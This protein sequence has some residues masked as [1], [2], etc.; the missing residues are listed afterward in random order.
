MKRITVFLIA[1]LLVGSI[2]YS[3]KAI[4]T[5]A[6]GGTGTHLAHK[7]LFHNNATFLLGNFGTTYTKYVNFTIDGHTFEQCPNVNW[8]N[9]M[10]KLNDDNSLAWFKH[11]TYAENED[12]R[13]DIYNA[14]LDS[15][16]NLFVLFRIEKGGKVVFGGDEFESN[17]YPFIVAKYS[18]NGT[19]IWHRKLNSSPE[20]TVSSSGNLVLVIAINRW[21]DFRFSHWDEDYF[22]NGAND[23]YGKTFRMIVL[24]GA[25]G[26]MVTNKVLTSDLYHS[27]NQDEIDLIE[28][29]S[30]DLSYVTLTK[31]GEH[32]VLTLSVDYIGE[33]NLFYSE[34]QLEKRFVTYGP[35]TSGLVKS[36]FDNT[37][38]R[39]TNFNEDDTKSHITKYNSSLTEVI[40]QGEI[41]QPAFFGRSIVDNDGNIIIMSSQFNSNTQYNGISLYMDDSPN[42]SARFT[43]LNSNLE[44]LGQK[45]LYYPWYSNSAFNHFG[46]NSEKNSIKTI[47]NES[48]AINIDTVLFYP[49]DYNSD[50]VIFDFENTGILPK[51]LTLRNHTTFTLNVGESKELAV[52]FFNPQQLNVEWVLNGNTVSSEPNYT[53]NATS[54]GEF[55]LSLKAYDPNYPSKVFTKHWQVNV[56][57]AE[58]QLLFPQGHPLYNNDIARFT[59]DSIG[60][61][62]WGIDKYKK[63]VY[64]VN[65]DNVADYTEWINPAETDLNNENPMEVRLDA[66]RNP[67]FLMSSGLVL[68]KS[69]GQWAK[70]SLTDMGITASPTQLC[71]IDGVM[72][73]STENGVVKTGEVWEDVPNVEVYTTYLPTYSNP[74][75]PNTTPTRKVFAMHQTTDGNFWIGSEYGLKNLTTG[76]TLYPQNHGMPFN[77]TL[78]IASSGN[79]LYFGDAQ[80][81]LVE[82]NVE[83]NKFRLFIL[84]DVSKE[85]Y[86]DMGIRSMSTDANGNVWFVNDAGGYGYGQG[87]FCLNPL[88]KRIT[89]YNP[90]VSVVKTIT[91]GQ[92]NTVYARIDGRIRVLNKEYVETQGVITFSVTNN[93]QPIENAVITINQE[94]LATNSNGLASVTLPFASYAYTVTHP[95]YKT[96][97]ANISFQEETTIEVI[98]QPSTTHNEVN[99]VSSIA[100]YPNPFNESILV[101]N[102]TNATHVEISTLSGVTVLSQPLHNNIVTTSNLNSGF[103]IISI[104]LKNGE[105]QVF[106]MVKQ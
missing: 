97:N 28:N 67:W 98:L 6:I 36:E 3:Q 101:Y 83:Q 100:L 103:Y 33:H 61:Y 84:F 1:T 10:L 29:N 77:R 74:G 85:F 73:I 38:I 99:F 92:N 42:N 8:T 30:I 75:E 51:S 76:D 55:N 48:Q 63:A 24:S 13:I 4:N 21:F 43:Y 105:K 66:D 96:F 26:S 47:G 69:S 44:L 104:Y 31:I 46:Y 45:H 54:K 56:T 78:S 12:V 62:F 90:N 20:F 60:N 80:N 19:L 79:N 32:S 102:H 68:E 49:S 7:A 39:L 27:L 65:L 9:Y 58:A 15:E 34:T 93:S 87:L 95:N 52:E 5:K 2:G 14:E 35:K 18:T 50:I 106:R 23:I 81:G 11:Q 59:I 17:G 64:Q 37:Y 72:H 25:D 88:S 16:G 89:H 82:Y 53:F 71:L 86:T 70:H 40:A 41:N 91:F 57:S 22:W 94:E